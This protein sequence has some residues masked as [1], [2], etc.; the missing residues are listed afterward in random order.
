MSNN[1]ITTINAGMAR[2]LGA[3][4][5]EL[6]GIFER[7]DMAEDEIRSMQQ[8]HPA[9]RDEL[10]HSFKLLQ[11]RDIGEGMYTEFVYLSHVRELLGRVVSGADLRP[12]T[13]AEMSVMCAEVSQ[14]VPMHGAGAGLYFRLW[15]KAFP[16]HPLT[17]E[18]AAQRV[19]YE[20]LFASQIDE[21]QAELRYRMADPQRRLVDIECEGKH[22]GK[23]VD[24][25]FV[26]HEGAVDVPALAAA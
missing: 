14:K 1:E 26:V 20:K 8:R 23:R 21:S 11:P 16:T 7:I 15:A 10:Y 13:Y 6:A 5:S 18:Q 3:V 9:H 19:H 25:R 4:A 17:V 22:H 12:A 2:L 24:C